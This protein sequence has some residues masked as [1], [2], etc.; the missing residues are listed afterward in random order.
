MTAVITVRAT[1]RTLIKLLEFISDGGGGPKEME[2][3]NEA[4]GHLITAWQEL[5]HLEAGNGRKRP[6][7]SV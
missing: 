7:T 3:V 5:D 2:I 1:V 4:L 6:K